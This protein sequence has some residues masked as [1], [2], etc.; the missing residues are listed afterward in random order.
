M[1]EHRSVPLRSALIVQIELPKPLADL[2]ARHDPL[3]T[4]GVPPHVTVLFPFIPVDD[5]GPSV[6]AALAEL[7]SAH[8][9]FRAR[10]DRFEHRDAM[11]WLPPVQ[12]G[13]FQELTE[14][15]VGRW[16]M[17]QPY[18]GAYDTLIPHLT[19]VESSTDAIARAT[20]AALVAGPFDVPVE[21]LLLIGQAESGDWREL[22]QFRLG[23]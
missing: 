4:R 17:Y 10:F 8:R 2:R 23:F 21:E 9:P 16:P 18:D 5:L 12:P 13:P 7:A 11:I 19:L 6:G 3:A 22:D 14:A 15:V 20:A 1:A